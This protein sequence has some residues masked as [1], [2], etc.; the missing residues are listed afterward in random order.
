M[1]NSIILPTSFER[2]KYGLRVRLATIEDSEFILSLRTNNNI[3]KYLHSIPKD[4]DIQRRWMIEYKE[5][6][7]RGEDYY[8]VFSKGEDR[9][10]L[11]RIYNI[12]DNYATS[13]SW[14]CKE[15]TAI[16]DVVATTLINRDVIFYELGKL[17][18]RFDVRKENKKVLRF[19]KSF[20]SV[21]IDENDIDYFLVL[22]EEDYRINK[23]RTINLLGYKCNPLDE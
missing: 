2:E 17:E 14:I 6:E 20:G 4:V 8:F 1:R 10:G 21:I 23:Q 18:D 11:I 16:A 22:K 5:R 19:H 15:G 7:R 13:G 12:N 3:N 9:I